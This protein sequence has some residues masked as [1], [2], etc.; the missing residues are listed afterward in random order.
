MVQL[1]ARKAGAIAA[2]TAVAWIAIG[3]SLAG[4]HGPTWDLAGGDYAFG[5]ALL[6]FLLRGCQGSPDPHEDPARFARREPGPL[7]EPGFGVHQLFAFGNLASALCGWLLFH[8][9]GTLPAFTAYHLPAILSAALVV[10]LSVYVAG[11]ARG[12][13][14]A[15]L[16]AVFFVGC[17]RFVGHAFSNLKDV[18]MTMLYNAAFA[19]GCLAIAKGHRWCFVVCGALAGLAFAQKPN[20]VFMPAQLLAVTPVFAALRQCAGWRPLLFGT[21]WAVATAG[22]AWIVASPQFWPL[23]DTNIA[24]AIARIGAQIQEIRTV[25][26]AG[27]QISTRAIGM[28]AATMP[29]AVLLAATAGVRSGPS[30]VR[31]ALWVAFT[32]PVL[33]GLLPG[34]RGFDGVR[35]FLEFVPPLV[36]LAAIGGAEILSRANRLG[37]RPAVAAALL[38]MVAP[39]T[40][41]TIRTYPY[42]ICYNNLVARGV[43]SCS[44]PCGQDYWGHSIWEA[45][46]VVRSETAPDT[47]TRVLV[48]VA[49]HIA[50]CAAPVVFSGTQ[51]ELVED[52]DAI[53]PPLVVVVLD[54]PSFFDAV[55]RHVTENHPASRSIRVLGRPIL[56]MH[57]FNDEASCSELSA[58]MRR[59]DA[60]RALYELW[61]GRVLAVSATPGREELPGLF[62]AVLQHTAEHGAAG[63]HAFVRNTFPEELH[64]LAEH[65]SEMAWHKAQ[66]RVR[67][68]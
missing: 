24:D 8:G 55:A 28:V 23:G 46:H 43:G 52:P 2:A 34:M 12:L 25:G 35:H 10:G 50:R 54:R 67:T 56:R 16:A 59:A 60:A 44:G 61:A 63:A 14:A 29:I 22:A 7:F 5:D 26:R 64:G 21:V 32:F 62:H 37:G 42:G 1:S 51:I 3:L 6:D 36:T 18:P 33:R 53:A 68:E 15:L 65:V 30:T 9:M 45:L 58:L 38:A 4:N 31:V 27:D 17:P 66:G 57:R 49:E 20:I 41:D 40:V 39:A 13:P 48:P 19:I 47:E 11:R